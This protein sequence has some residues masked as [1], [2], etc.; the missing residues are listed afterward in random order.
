MEARPR[1]SSDATD[2]QGCIK[3]DI[4]SMNRKGGTPA[5]P[6][7]NRQNHRA[8]RVPP[9]RWQLGF[10]FPLEPRRRFGYPVS[11]MSEVTVILDRLHSGDAPAIEELLPLV[12]EELRRLAASQ[13]AHVRPGHTLQPTA[14]VHEAYLRLVG[15]A[16]QRWANSRHFFS[17]AAEAMR[18]ILVDR[19]RARGSVK[20]G[21]EWLRVDLDNLDVAAEDQPDTLLFVDE[22]LAKFAVVDPDC[23]ELIKLRFFAGLSNPQAA[24]MLGMSERTAKRNWAY[25]RVW[26]AREIAAARQAAGRAAHDARTHES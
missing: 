22:A 25:A 9:F 23:A 14:L 3:L 21:G 24:A 6:G 16:D 5:A 11:I 4:F 26:L 19:L 17:A 15:Q 7:A 20:R 18:H 1:N 10:N 13:M 8:A 12:Y 2:G